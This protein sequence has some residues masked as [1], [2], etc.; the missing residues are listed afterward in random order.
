MPVQYKDYYEILG[1]PRDATEEEI[2]KAFRKLARQ[3]HPDVAKDKK[4][5]EEKFKEINEAYEVLSNPETRKKY[6]ALGAAWRNGEQ[7]GQQYPG[8]QGGRWTSPDGTTHYEF[9]FGG[10]GYSDF[11]ERFFSGGGRFSGFEDLLS[12]FGGGNDGA[13]TAEETETRRRGADIEGNIMVTLE[14][15]LKGSIRTISL[16]RFSPETG[17]KEVH[18]FKVRIPAGVK[19][20]QLIRVPGKGHKGSGG[21]APGDL[22][23]RVRFAAHPDFKVVGNDIYYELELAPWD[24]VLGK[25]VSIP[26]LDGNCINVKVPQGTNNGQKL[27][28]RG[29]G[30]PDARTKDRGDLYVVVNVKLPQTITEQERKLWEELRRVSKFNPQED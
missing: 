9:H 12:S 24:A 20:G 19:D 26:T 10:T 14:E 1:V 30:L 22:Y 29:Y 13:G 18:T 8:W 6:D 28:V 7:F 23:L 2:K 21:G 4:A 16:E 25:T 3:Y 15:A 11:F 5:A 17:Q 27:R